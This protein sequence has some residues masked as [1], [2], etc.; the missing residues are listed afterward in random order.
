MLEA[1]TY[2]KDK[3]EATKKAKEEGI[4]Q[5]LEQGSKAK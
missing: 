5:G 4:E 3:M 1:Y 2:Y